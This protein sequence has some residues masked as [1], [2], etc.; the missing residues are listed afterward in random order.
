MPAPALILGGAQIASSLIGGLAGRKAA[1]KSAKQIKAL[2]AARAEELTRQAEQE[3]ELRVEQKKAE[4]DANK[5]RMEQIS[6]M[7]SKSGLLLTGTPAVAMQQQ[8]ETDIYNIQQGDEA[9]QERARRL[10]E[11]AKIEI[12]SAE[13]SAKGYET[14]GKTDLYSGI[15]GAGMGAAQLAGP[16]KN[17]FGEIGGGGGKQN[18]AQMFDMLKSSQLNLEGWK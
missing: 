10:R 3:D 14:Q 11:A 13:L 17:W 6:G 7:Y 2:G 15:L 12:Q 18:Q 4:F 1:K 16:L 5:R 9:A 8:K